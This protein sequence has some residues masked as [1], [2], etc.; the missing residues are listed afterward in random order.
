MSEYSRQVFNSTEESLS[1]KKKSFL[2]AIGTI[3]FSPF[4]MMASPIAILLEENKVR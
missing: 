1:L 3:I 4:I 2:G